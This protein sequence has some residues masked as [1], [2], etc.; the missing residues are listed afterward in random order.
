MEKE[1][2]KMLVCALGKCVLLPDLTSA[3]ATDAVAEV[4]DEGAGGKEDVKG[5]GVTL[6]AQS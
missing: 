4:V 5:R 1:L 3:T 6:R 2:A